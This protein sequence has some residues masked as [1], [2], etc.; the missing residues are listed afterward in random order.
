LTV[1]TL[2]T[3]PPIYLTPQ[4][5]HDH[6]EPRRTDRGP[7]RDREVLLLRVLA[8]PVIS[9]ACLTMMPLLQKTFDAEEERFSVVK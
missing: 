6:D 4:T 7:R 8:L 2:T 3:F 5:E 1:S 9:M